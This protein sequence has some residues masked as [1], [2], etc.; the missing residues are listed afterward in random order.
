MGQK[1]ASQY[2]TLV[3]TVSTY[4][5]VGELLVADGT[6]VHHAQRWLHPMHAHVSL[7]VALGGEG[8]A[9]DFALKRPFASVCAVVHLQDTLTAK[10]P[11]AEEA[12]VWVLEFVLDIVYQLLQ[13]GS[14]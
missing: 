1:R 7:Q 10:H 5:C 13:F 4:Q 8:T 9:T 14:F 6:L 3:A 12:L 2:E 11:L